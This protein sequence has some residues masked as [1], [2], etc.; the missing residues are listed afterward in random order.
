LAISRTA[1]LAAAGRLREEATMALR[2]FL[3]ELRERRVR[4][5]GDA[6]DMF[7]SD[8]SVTHVRPGRH[9]ARQGGGIQ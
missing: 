9:L 8:L 6:L 3:A 1:E 7:L 5:F 4:V 2:P